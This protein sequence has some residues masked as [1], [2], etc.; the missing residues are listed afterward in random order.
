MKLTKPLVVLDLETTGTWIEKDKILEIAM[1]K[2]S[3]D[4]SKTIY[5]KRINPGI[6]IPAC[7]TKL[8]GISDEAV[9]AAPAFKDV[10]QEIVDF[11]KDCDLAGFNIERFDLPVLERELAECGIKFNFRELCTYDAQRIFHLNEKR[12]LSAA[13]K[14]YCKKTLENAHTALADTQATLEIIDAQIKEYSEDGC[15][16]RLGVF[17]YKETSDFFDCDRKFRWWNGKL[18]MMFGKYAKSLTLQDI[19]KRDPQY[20]EWIL[21]ANFSEEVKGLIEDALRGKYPAPPKDESQATAPNQQAG[22]SS[23]YQKDK[24]GN[25]LLFK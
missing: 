8:T 24:D 16:E 6:P 1:I 9:K 11:I 18:Y 4:G 23:E 20:L 19:V 13:Y 5:D 3:P 21:S 17:S 12:D 10:A 25:P 2:V 14:F 15:V 22:G 7:I